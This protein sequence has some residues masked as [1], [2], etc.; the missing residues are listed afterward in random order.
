MIVITV[1]LMWGILSV[2]VTAAWARAGRH[3]P[4]CEPAPILLPLER[5]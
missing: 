4:T 2:A 3:V 1:L 5:R